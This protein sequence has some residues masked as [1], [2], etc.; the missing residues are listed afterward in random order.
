[1]SFP[2]VILTCAR[3]EDGE[4][5]RYLD[6]TIAQ[7]EAERPGVDID[8]HV[9]CD[10][11]K[12]DAP[13]KLPEGWTLHKFAREHDTIAG[14][15]LAYFFA[16]RVA[17]SLNAD[18]ALVFEDDVAFCPNALRRM[19][20][21]PIPPDLSFVMFYA[22]AVFQHPRIFPGL[23]RTPTPV[24]GTQAIKFSRS[25]LRKF[26]EFS[27]FEAFNAFHASDQ[28]LEVGR[29]LL[30]MK[31]GAHCPE[32]VQHV[33]DESAVDVGADLSHRWRKSQTF[34]AQLDAMA[35]YARDE[36]FR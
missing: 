35:L 23:W 25:A 1:L 9:V 17:L 5:Y 36:L 15:K 13:P 27:H 6:A 2:V 19:V 10:V 29:G 14:N 22:P 8:G 34:A 21:F 20:T 28:I 11:T 18:A 31:Y 33:G 30:G 3:P 32:I 7:I 26:D 16:L 4:P 24:V 12:A